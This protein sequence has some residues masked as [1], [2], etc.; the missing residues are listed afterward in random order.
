[1]LLYDLSEE[2]I[3]IFR[4]RLSHCTG[5]LEDKPLK[6]TI[7]NSFFDETIPNG[8]PILTCLY[9]LM[10]YKFGNFDV[11]CIFIMKQYPNEDPKFIFAPTFFG[12][13]IFC[14]NFNMFIVFHNLPMELTYFH[15]W[16]CIDFE[17]KDIILLNKISIIRSY[18]F[19]F[20]EFHDAVKVSFRLK[21]DHNV[22]FEFL[23][24]HP[25]FWRWFEIWVLSNHILL[26]IENR[27]AMVFIW[28]FRT[29]S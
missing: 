15:V 24:R 27:G 12:T 9:K 1:M 11:N 19:L 2:S 22:L 28:K 5:F 14:S 13:M 7:F 21:L 20:D 16:K 4:P 25:T 18:A 17:S 26:F 23:G 29:I 10:S 8:L 3:L 6:A